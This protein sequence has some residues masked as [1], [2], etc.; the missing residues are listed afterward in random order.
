MGVPSPSQSVK[1]HPH[2]CLEELRNRC[3]TEFMWPAR[4]VRY[5]MFIKPVFDLLCTS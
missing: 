1:L 4:N 3:V 2:M 5:G